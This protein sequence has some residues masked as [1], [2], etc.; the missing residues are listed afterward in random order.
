LLLSSENWFSLEE[1][2]TMEPPP[3]VGVGT[4]VTVGVAVGVAVGTGVGVGE[5]VGVAVGVGV[6]VGVA[7]GVVV[8]VYVGV[9]LGVAVAAGAANPVYHLGRGHWVVGVIGAVSIVTEEEWSLP[10][11]F[12]CP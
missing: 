11:T 9:G 8:G 5:G 1:I 6:L 10:I 12:N 3:P 4:G 2:K 7:V